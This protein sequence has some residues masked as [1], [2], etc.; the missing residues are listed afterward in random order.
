MTCPWLPV[1]H[2]CLPV[3]TCLCKEETYGDMLLFPE[4]RRDPVLCYRCRN[5]LIP[6]TE[7]QCDERLRRLSCSRKAQS[8][9]LGPRRATGMV[10]PGRRRA[11]YGEL[12]IAHDGSE[13]CIGRTPTKETG[14]HLP[15]SVR[16]MGMAHLMSVV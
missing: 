8:M 11:T 7:L 5:S 9:L 2:S 1:S 14:S 10:L 4:N 3:M 15:A 13:S 6:L 12:P 16:M